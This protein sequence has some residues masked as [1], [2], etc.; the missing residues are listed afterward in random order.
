[1]KNWKL[2]MAVVLGGLSLVG[3]GEQPA[4]DDGSETP[5]KPTGFV[6]SLSEDVQANLAENQYEVRILGVGNNFYKGAYV[7]VDS[8]TVSAGGREL[9]VEMKATVM[10]LARP[11]HAALVGYFTLPPG[12]DSAQVVIRL[13]EYGA[14]EDGRRI[15][16]LDVRTAPLRF[17]VTRALLA[18]RKH[19]VVHLD[20][21]HSVIVPPTG[22]AMLMPTSAVA[23]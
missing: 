14:F 15:G 21:S 19:A 4:P 16:A 1:M 2:W 3:C 20:L 18:P 8:M 13:D 23:F 5:A 6:P 17:E 7:N 22:D 10:D 12:V 11:D 9:P